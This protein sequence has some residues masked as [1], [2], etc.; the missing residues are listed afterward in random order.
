MDGDFDIDWGEI[1]WETPT[2]ATEDG[3]ECTACEG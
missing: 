1:S 3:S 2:R